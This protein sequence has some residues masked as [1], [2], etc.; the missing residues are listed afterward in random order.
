VAQSFGTNW[1][2]PSEQTGGCVGIGINVASAKIGLLER[3]GYIPEAYF[4]LP[5]R[6]WFENYY[7]PM[8][9]RFDAF[10]K[11]H[12]QSEHAKAIVEAEQH[13]IALYEKYGEYYS[14]GVYIAKNVCRPEV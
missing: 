3:H 10:L 2:L 8:Q 5:P 11:Q 7:R 6:C 14:Y 4:F 13:E 1:R 12:E 9:D